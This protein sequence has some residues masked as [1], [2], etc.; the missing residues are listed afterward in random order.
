VTETDLIVCACGALLI[1]GD[2]HAELAL[3]FDCA[4]VEPGQACDCADCVA[5][6]E[7]LFAA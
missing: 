7:L 2:E 4:A 3:C 6:R 1:V 5:A